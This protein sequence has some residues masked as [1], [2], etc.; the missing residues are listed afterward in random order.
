LWNSSG[1]RARC[2]GWVAA[3]MNARFGGWRGIA[4]PAIQA[5]FF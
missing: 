2:F 5:E 1:R 4:K 3:S